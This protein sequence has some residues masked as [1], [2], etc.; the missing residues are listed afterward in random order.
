V[1]SEHEEDLE[2]PRVIAHIDLDAFFAAVHVLEDPALADKPLVVGGR[3]EG[4]GVVATASYPARAYGI[5]SAMPMYLAVERCPDL[6]IVP[7]QHD[8]YRRYSRRVMDLVRSSSPLV[9]QMSVDEAYIDWSERVTAW[10]EGIGLA[11]RL[12]AQIEAQVGLSASLGIATNKLVAKVASD[13]DKPAG[14]TVVRPGEEAAFLASLPVRALWG[15]GPVTAANLAEMG[16][17][18]VGELARRPERDLR[19]RFGRHGGAMARH[20]QGIDERPVVTEHERKSVSQ[21]RTFRRDVRRL[22]PLKRHL[23]KMSQGV[24][25]RLQRADLAAGTVAIK[26]RY[27]DFTTFTRQMSLMLPTDDAVEIY[28]AALALLDRA[29]ERKRPVRLLGVSG[30]QLDAPSPQMR[31]C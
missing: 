16:I 5:H 25:D 14:L 12:Q 11:R 15:I 26:V 22:E 4:R 8:L 23:W 19:Q 29:W 24:A 6:I 2:R 20:A 27:A 1:S 17:E 13:R 3:P 18:T 9:E 31:L 30:R 28:G 7:P 10:E 21:E